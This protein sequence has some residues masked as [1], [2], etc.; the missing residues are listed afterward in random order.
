MNSTDLPAPNRR[1]PGWAR[2][3]VRLCAVL[4]LAFAIGVVLNHISR[5]LSRDPKPAGFSRGLLQGALMP[6]AFPNLLVGRDVNIYSD[7]NTG[8]AYKLGYTSGVNGCGAVFFGGL[9]WRVTRWR[10]TARTS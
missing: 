4:L 10:R 7:H 9:F 6:M 5:T 3:F 2:F 8:V 1:L